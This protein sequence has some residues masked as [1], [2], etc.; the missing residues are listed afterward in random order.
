MGAS[1]HVAC[2]H[3]QAR[4]DAITRFGGCAAVRHTAR[5][6]EGQPPGEEIVSED[7]Q[8]KREILPTPDVPPYHVEDT[9]AAP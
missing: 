1:V 4:N 6:A 5:F 8:V 7:V 3:P 9:G 2:R